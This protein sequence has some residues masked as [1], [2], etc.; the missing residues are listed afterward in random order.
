MRMCHPCLIC[1]CCVNCDVL[2]FAQPC[3]MFLLTFIFNLLKI[4]EAYEPINLPELS[5][6]RLCGW[7]LAVKLNLTDKAPLSFLSNILVPLCAT[8]KKI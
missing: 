8:L 1:L 5:C 7:V 6:L 2:S 4:N 3:V